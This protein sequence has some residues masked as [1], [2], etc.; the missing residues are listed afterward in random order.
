MG[1]EPETKIEVKVEADKYS[2]SLATKQTKTE[3]SREVFTSLEEAIEVKIQKIK[4]AKT[5]PIFQ[6]LGHLGTD[7]LATVAIGAA[8]KVE[9]SVP[10]SILY[11]SGV[12]IV[13]YGNHLFFQHGDKAREKLRQTR[14]QLGKLLEVQKQNRI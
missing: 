9:Q 8:M 6:G 5:I 10:S 1:K 13:V 14:E 3:E 11:A 4:H 7:I 12:S 2:I